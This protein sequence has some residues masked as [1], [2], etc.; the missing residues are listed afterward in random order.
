MADITKEILSGSTDGQPI[1][2]TGTDYA[3]RVTVHTAGSG[4]T[5]RDE[6]Y[7]YAYVDD[8]AA[9]TNKLTIVWDNGTDPDDLMHVTL[10]AHGAAGDDGLIPVL[11]GIPIQNA[12][13]ISAYAQNANQVLLVGWVN[14]HDNTA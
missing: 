2:I 11:A 5:N 8:A 4:T 3:G 1:K 10:P 9:T 13:V 6:V 12:K 14:R 7:L